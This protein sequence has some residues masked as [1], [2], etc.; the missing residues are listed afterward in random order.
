MG[1]I[2]YHKDGTV[3]N[4]SEHGRPVAAGEEGNLLC[5]AQEDYGRKV[6]VDLVNGVIAFDYERLGMQNGT[7]ELENPKFMFWICE[8]TNIV[9][10]FRHLTQELVWFKD[11]NGKYIRDSEGHGQK[12]RNDI[13]TPLLWRPIW[14]TRYTMGQ[15]TKVIGAQTTTPDM[16]G[17]RNIKK[18]VSIFIDGR[19]GI[20]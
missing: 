4:E 6:A 9:G 8:E 19:I 2:A 12:V 1:W 17:A 13:L 15:P 16:Q 20:D 11:E 14:F 10:E 18:M 3:L 7:L 5:I